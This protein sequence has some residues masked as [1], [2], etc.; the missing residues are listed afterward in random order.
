M[1]L[2][3]LA[4]PLF[5]S[6]VAGLLGRKIGVTGAHI[7]TTGSLMTTAAL[8]LVAFY[9]VGL[10][11]S[12]VSIEL[13]SWIDSEFMMVSWGFLFDSLTVSMLL[14]VLIVSSLVHL[15][16]ISYMAED[17]HNQRFFSYL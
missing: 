8:A 6:A 7:I 9:E 12:S 4:L 15:Y 13:F 10:C 5:G 16:S 2:S 11:G 3:I 14:P 17:P 1:Y